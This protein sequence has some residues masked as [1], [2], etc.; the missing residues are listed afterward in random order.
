[1]SNFTIRP[2]EGTWADED[3]DDDDDND[4][5]LGYSRWM[6][7]VFGFVESF[8]NEPNQVL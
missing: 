5:E 6:W 7:Q 4:D 8:F 1:M 2:F 3:D